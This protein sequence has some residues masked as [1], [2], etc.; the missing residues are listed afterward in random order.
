M[1]GPCGGWTLPCGKN[2]RQAVAVV[3][4]EG[5]CAGAGG[6]GEPCRTPQ[7]KMG[8][9]SCLSGVPGSGGPGVVGGWMVG[10]HP[11]RE[12]RQDRGLRGE[13]GHLAG[14]RVHGLVW[15]TRWGE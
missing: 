13:A 9:H 5:G 11:L 2:C 8:A 14:L 1:Q 10:G 7:R 4:G 3:G 12:W 6:R 15:G